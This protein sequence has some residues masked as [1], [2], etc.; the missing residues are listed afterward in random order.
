MMIP[1]RIAAARS[2]EEPDRLRAFDP[3][4]FEDFL[5]DVAQLVHARDTSSR[6]W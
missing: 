3:Q 5:E 2:A 4:R 6:L 1:R